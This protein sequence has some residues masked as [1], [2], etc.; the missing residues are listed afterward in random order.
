MAFPTSPS[1]GQIY[2]NYIYAGSNT[3]TK[4]PAGIKESGTNGNG[5]YTWFIDGTLMQWGDFMR[6]ASLTKA[7]NASS[8]YEPYVDGLKLDFP[9]AFGST[10]YSITFSAGLSFSN[11]PFYGGYET[12]TRTSSYAYVS[13]MCNYPYN[14][15]NVHCT[16]MLI[17][18]K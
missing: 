9:V 18:T 1:G 13:L 3:W 2:K 17:G 12:T 11:Y 5:S 6:I 14:G 8:S 4:M 7:N 15:S 10:D 16:F